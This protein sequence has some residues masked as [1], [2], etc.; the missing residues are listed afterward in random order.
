[1]LFSNE[2]LVAL[3]TLP[4][5]V[6]ILL[7]LA[8]SRLLS[9]RLKGILALV[10]TLPGLAAIIAAF[11][12]VASSGPIHF[13]AFGWDGP[14]AMVFHVDALSLMFALMGTGLG[15][16]VLL[17]S[18]GYMAHDRSATR[19]YCF[20]LTFIC[21]M[22]GLV[23][24]AN[25]F[26]LY[27]CWEAMG[28]CSF[29]LVGF[30]YDQPAAVAGA[31]KVLL[32]T[33]LA[34]YGLLAAILL[35]FARTGSAL[36][37]DPGVAQAFTTGVYLLMLVAL[38]AKS[39]QFP[40]HTWIPEAMNA[41]TPVSAL[42]HAACYVKAGVYLAARMHGLAPWHASWGL[43][44]MWLGTVTMV[45]GVAYAMVQHD[46]KRMLAFHT[47]S[48]I[49][50][51]ITGLGL[52]TP[53]GIAAG[54][55]HCLNHS[56]FKGGLFLA[57]GSV[58]HATGTRDMNK[59]GG[60]NRLMP[61]TS[62]VWMISVC[63][64]MG[65][66]FLSGFASKWLLYTA[67]L[68]AGQVV[69]ALVAWLVSIGTVFSCVKAT[70]SVFLGPT[71][72]ESA[73][74]HEAPI[75]MQVALGLFAAGSLVLGLA[76]QLAINFII[77]PILPVLGLSTVQ[78][79]WFGLTPAA[80][81]W[82]TTGGLVL[83]IVSALVGFI[84]YA[85]AGSSRA[86]IATQQ[87]AVATAG[88]AM[89]GSGNP[90]IFT[91]GETLNGPSR[92]PAGEFSVMLKKHWAPFYSATD[93]D[94][95]Y[96]GGWRI[97]EGASRL[98]NGALAWAES[99]VIFWTLLLTAAVFAA[100]QG[101]G[102]APANLAPE[103]AEGIAR[104]I[105]LGCSIAFGALLLSAL[106]QKAFRG[107]VP[108]LA[109]SGAAAVAAA[110]VSQPST[111]LAL[112]EAASVLA[113]IQV[114]QRASRH[115]AWLYG[116]VVA[117]SAGCLIA[118]QF[119]LQDNLS[120]ALLLTGF[121]LK[122]GLVPAFLWLPTLAV[123][124]P[125]LTLGL[126]IAIVDIVAFG[127]LLLA[128]QSNPA[129][130]Q[131]QSFWIAIA[132]ATSLIAAVRMLSERNIKRM[133]ALSTLEDSGFLLLGLAAATSLGL[134]GA[135]V[136]ATVHALA[137]ALLFISISTPDGDG[138]LD[139]K[140]LATRYPFSA[141]GF[142]AGML[143]MLGVPPMLG[144]AGRWRLYM[145]AFTLHPALLAAFIFC[146]ICALIAYVLCVTR[147]WWGEW[148]GGEQS[149]SPESP[150]NRLAILVLIVLLLVAGLWPSALLALAGGL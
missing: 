6:G 132:L 18:I 95:V 94:R 9:A 3:A 89:L 103:G 52:G 1:M 81:S 35:I 39:V 137:K 57:A 55:L 121:V 109:L 126:I 138:M 28:L 73:K 142:I 15:S 67:A 141:G 72:A 70:S 20:M 32:M 102:Y 44:M 50:Y 21:G 127:E 64:M 133:L 30:W 107:L 37:T 148:N 147:H 10:C 116:S 69:P 150:L 17:Y 83:G 25:L 80:G 4:L 119:V 118:A 144:F 117:V 145:T 105:A 131:P 128:A 75:T 78:V 8:F 13:V 68:Q 43:T 49:G 16:F 100:V 120:H 122:L 97:L 48:Q 90:G 61:R 136:A 77:N 41:P 27:L 124:L 106:G 34:G 2:N 7:Q 56:L 63:S 96:L 5:L 129:L 53:L 46:L 101:F 58:Q 12:R 11:F 38:L 88:G 86:R 125:A 91:G 42:L 24:S 108:L 82:W 110:F 114:A 14:L 79:S 74:A 26:S 85:L 111:R 113:L 134:Q 60:L 123:E 98:F 93:V 112:L 51:I 29:S 99:S 33:H 54:L 140:G 19:F 146:S 31:R 22:V 115:A 45:V 92:L 76:P 66:P 36:W 104:M 62:I 135:M 149:T 65:V 84:L 47:V 23:I 40:L 71:T 59:L 130:L 143:A 87:L 139:R